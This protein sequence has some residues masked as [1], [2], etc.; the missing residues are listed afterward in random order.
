MMTTLDLQEQTPRTIAEL[1]Q[2]CRLE[3]DRADATA[4]T[5]VEIREEQRAL[6]AKAIELEEG[7]RKNSAT[8]GALVFEVGAISAAVAA[9][10][11]TLE[12]L[13]AMANGR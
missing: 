13:E 5:L 12:R 1:L 2:T 8:L 6:T 9:I 7:H 3:A 11:A 4:V 10:K